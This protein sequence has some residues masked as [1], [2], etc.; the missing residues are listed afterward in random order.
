MT[1]LKISNFNGNTGMHIAFSNVSKYL[2]ALLIVTAALFLSACTFDRSGLS[3]KVECI[4]DSDCSAGEICRGSF[5][6]SAVG[7]GDLDAGL[8]ASFFDVDAREGEGDGTIADVGDDPQEDSTEDIVPL[9]SRDDGS[10]DLTEDGSDVSEDG[11]DISDD[12]GCDPVNACGGCSELS[13]VPDTECG[14]E[15]CGTGTWEC[16]G[17]ESVECVSEDASLNACGGCAE[18]DGEIEGE[19]GECGQF[20]CSDD[21]ESLECDDPGEN[22]CGG[23]DELEHP[24][25]EEC[26]VCGGGVGECNDDGTSSCVG[27]NPTNGCGT[28]VDLG[29]APTAECGACFDGTLACNDDGTALICEGATPDN[30]CGGC[31]VVTDTPGTA[32]GDCNGLWTCNGALTG[33]TCE[34]ATSF[35]DCGGCETLDYAPETD[36]GTCLDGTWTCDGQ[37]AVECLG[38]SGI[39]ACGGCGLLEGAPD[40]LCGE[41]SDGLWTCN[42]DNTAVT[43]EGQSSLNACGGCVSLDHEPDTG[44]SVCPGGLWT[45]TEAKDSVTCEGDPGLNLCGGCGELPGEENDICSCDGEGEAKYVCHEGGM[46]CLE[47]YNSK[48]DARWLEAATENQSREASGVIDSN[49]EWDWF[50]V[51]TDDVRG[52]TMEPTARITTNNPASQSFQICVFYQPGWGGNYGSHSCGGGDQCAR[53]DAGT[54]TIVGDNCWWTD[55]FENDADMHGCCESDPDDQGRWTARMTGGPTRL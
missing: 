12:G 27:A 55:G 33:V 32:C 2:G 10:E 45:C 49:G 44:C 1:E 22:E 38:A 4:D 30:A 5:C 54:N 51:T 20:E 46:V 19:C 6:G 43:C 3:E 8:E 40:D 17:Q 25:D 13:A 7:T 53:Y 35:N 41:C 21:G 26:G 31:G 28:C 16:V 29:G 14:G 36:C 47:P 24:V 42:G 39:N 37:N 15:G 50:A 9:D 34:G 18:L 23:C 48:S 52:S 11:S